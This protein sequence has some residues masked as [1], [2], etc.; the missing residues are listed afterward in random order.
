MN[1]IK[2]CPFCKHFAGFSVIL[3]YEEDPG[4]VA[5]MF[6]GAETP[7]DIW[8]ARPIED[9]L[10]ARIAELEAE[11][12]E[13]KPYKYGYSTRKKPKPHEWVIVDYKEH[14]YF[15]YYDEDKRWVTQYRDNIRDGVR[16][17][18]PAPVLSEDFNN[19][20]A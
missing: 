18:Y 19:D 11:V 2:P 7:F 13:L 17:W 16:R 3:P 4:R 6:C 1:E 9:A 20:P 10:Q 12:E 14:L 5:C 8:N 15:G